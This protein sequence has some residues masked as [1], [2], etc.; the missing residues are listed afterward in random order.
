MTH[1]SV[2][3]VLDRSYLE[4]APLVACT[5]GSETTGTRAPPKNLCE[6]S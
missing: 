4:A 5:T 1:H 3:E 6:A 2:T